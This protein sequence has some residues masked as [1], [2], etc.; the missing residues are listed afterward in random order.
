MEAKEVVARDGGRS[1]LFLF[2]F[3]FLRGR[4]WFQDLEGC[5]SIQGGVCVGLMAFASWLVARLF[6]WWLNHNDPD[7]E[8][9][10][11]WQEKREERIA[12]LIL[13]SI[14]HPHSAQMWATL[15]GIDL[16]ADCR[17]RLKD[18]ILSGVEAVTGAATRGVLNA[19]DQRRSRG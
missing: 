19:R 17:T 3:L 4:D 10:L 9:E 8:P 2:L 15:Y 5:G 7:P 11:G 14:E 18:G 13:L 12:D 1:F 6:I 16:A